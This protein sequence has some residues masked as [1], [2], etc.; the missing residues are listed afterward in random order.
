MRILIICDSMGIGGAETHVLSLSKGLLRCGCEVVVAAK[1]GELSGRLV[2]ESGGKIEFFSLYLRKKS[3]IEA[4]K[5]LRKLKKLIEAKKPDIVH[6]HSR[7]S[8]AAVSFIR[9]FT[10]VSFKLVVTAHAKYKTNVM[11]KLFSKWGEQTISVSEDIKEHLVRNYRRNAEKITVINNGVDMDEFSSDSGRIGQRILFASRLDRDC[12]LGAECLVKIADRIKEK[13]PIC[14]ITIVGGGEKFEEIKELAK[15]RENVFLVG[16][17]DSLSRQIADSDLVVGVSRVA[18]E[19]MACGKNI[20]LFGNEGALGLLT[21]ENLSDAQKTNFTCR[22]F[23]VRGEDFLY[24]QILRFF[25]LYD[26][27]KRNMAAENRKL[28]A[29]E[30]S[31]E[32]MAQRTLD[33]YKRLATNKPN[34]VICG[35]YGFGNMGDEALLSSFLSTFGDNLKISVLYNPKLIKE[36]KNN[37]RF[38]SRTAIFDVIKT[39]TKGDFFILGGGSLLQNQTSNRSLFYYSG[40]VFLAK[41]MGCKCLLIANGLGQINGK[42]AKKLTSLTL[43]CMDYASFRD[44]DSKK[45]ASALC[46]KE[47][48]SSADLCFN[49]KIKADYSDKVRSLLRS[50][51]GKYALVALKGNEKNHKTVQTVINTLK[52]QGI[53]PIFVAMDTKNDAKLAVEL[54]GK[55]GGEIAKSLSLPELYA[56][57][58]KCE[59]AIGSRLHF[60]IFALMSKTKLIG[61]GESPKVRA[62]LKDNF[63]IDPIC[64][65]NLGELDEIWQKTLGF[66]E[67]KIGNAL[68]KNILLAKYEA[69]KL[70]H[71]TFIK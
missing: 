53:T 48:F 17:V 36:N 3:P 1:E 10:G 50:I 69:N 8:S 22:G 58:G 4:I 41:M 32:R 34:V 30:Y 49:L 44:S 66:D 16:K 60:L 56:L 47:F 15:D 68:K 37:V 20:L 39:L 62:F 33:V 7:I 19:G 45:L 2:A 61:I 14:R 24:E 64:D 52:S 23:G 38:V 25:E 21:D 9:H 63:E 6:S 31:Q 12:S 70:N 29:R 42:F 71:V 40:L 26:R 59:I 13:Y 67:R 27:E 11:T 43:K 54:S 18:L 46:D 35:Y 5:Y 65:K 57:F 51:K 55:Y 28:M